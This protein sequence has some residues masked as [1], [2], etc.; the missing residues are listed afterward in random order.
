MTGVQK[1]ALPIS[2]HRCNGCETFLAQ[3]DPQTLNCRDCGTEIKWS[4]YEQLLVQ[5]GK[6]KKPEVCPDCA[7][8]EFSARRDNE[9]VTEDHHHVVRIPAGGK[10]GSDR[11]IAQWPPHLDHEVVEKAE[12]ADIR[13]VALGDDATYSAAD[14]TE[15]WPF[16][17]EEKLNSHLMDHG[18]TAVV[19]NAGM[20]ET[21]SAQALKRLP[22]DVWPFAPHL[23]LTSL[24]CGDSRLPL[25]D[26]RRDWQNAANAEHSSK[27]MEQLLRTLKKGDTEVVFWTPNPIFPQELI[28]EGAENGSRAW[29]EAQQSRR[30]QIQSHAIHVCHTL[31][32]PVLD[33]HARFEVN[34]ARSARKWM[35]DWQHHNAAGARNIA[36]WMADYILSNRGEL[37]GIE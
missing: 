18:K 12:A 35:T 23:V 16:L 10:W 11:K 28:R 20:P 25:A 37:L 21:T 6:F 7:E 15:S 32:I 2:A 1:C 36:T 29:A 8:K 34:G 5:R 4:A 9:P 27:E 30:N 26:A 17:L 13:I 22:R 14:R 31:D 33:L 3:H 19:V 24:I